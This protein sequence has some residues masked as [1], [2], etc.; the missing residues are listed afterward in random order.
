MNLSD[1]KRKDI[2][3]IVEIKLPKRTIERFNSI[4]FSSGKIFFVGKVSYKT[5]NEGFIKLYFYDPDL[6]KNLD[7][8]KKN[9]VD[10]SN[11]DE[12]YQIENDNEKFLIISN[13]YFD[14]VIVKILG[15]YK[16]L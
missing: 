6:F 5:E 3:E 7:N 9:K 11:N 2:I 12:S 13:Y 14:K 4:N 1:V 16:N 10:N 15:N 8:I